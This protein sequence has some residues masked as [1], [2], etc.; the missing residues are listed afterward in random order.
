MSF[1]YFETSWCKLD[2]QGQ[3]YEIL[4]GVSSGFAIPFG[5]LL[6][7]TNEV[8]RKIIYSN[9]QT[10]QNYHSAPWKLIK[11]KYKIDE[12]NKLYLTSVELELTPKKGNLIV[13]IFG[14][15]N[16]FLSSVN[17]DIELQ[18]SHVRK[19]G[20]KD[21]YELLFLKIENGILTEQR[22]EI[23]YSALRNY[24]ED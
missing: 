4:S 15:E 14:S 1:P 12:D 18:L 24:V 7:D 6:N 22:K 19:Y 8:K 23:K 20:E 11:L 3:E 21:M 13:D 16:I 5:K 2:Y 10:K 9:C 17:T